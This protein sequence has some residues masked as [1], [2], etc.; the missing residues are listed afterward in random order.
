VLIRAVAALRLSGL[1]LA[2][3]ALS[4]SAALWASPEPES[5]LSP[6]EVSASRSREGERARDGRH[7]ELSELV[8]EGGLSVR[9]LGGMGSASVLSARGGGAHQLDLSLEG[10]PL[11][12]AQSQGFDLS[13]FPSLVFQG[14][15]LSEGVLSGGSGAQTAQ[16]NLRLPRLEQGS[17]QRA[18]LM[19]STE[20]GAELGL[21]AGQAGEG[22]A[23]GVWLAY[24]GG[25]GAFR[26]RDRY[27]LLKRR[28]GADFER[29]SVGL[30]AQ[31]RVADR[32]L[33]GFIALAGLERGEPGPEGL[34]A[35]RGLSE[36]G[37]VAASLRLAPIEQ[38]GSWAPEGQ[39]FMSARSYLYSEDQPLWQSAEALRHLMESRLGGARL[40]WG[41]RPLASAER[42][43]E[44][45][46]AGRA[47]EAGVTLDAR[48]EESLISSGEEATLRHARSRLA[49]SPR[50]ALALPSGSWQLIALSGAARLDLN[51]ERSA[52]WIPSLSLAASPSASARCEL[53]FSRAFR[54]PSFDERYLRGPG[55]IPNPSLSFEDGWWTDLGCRLKLQGR[56]SS[57]KLSALGFSQVY[58]RLI[59]YVPLDPYRIQASDD[60]GAE[61][62]GVTLRAQLKHRLSAP[63]PVLRLEGQLTGQR[64][65][66][67]S[68]P[69]TPLPLRPELYAWGRLAL[70]LRPSALWLKLSHRGAL[71]ADR[72]GLRTLA[73]ATLLDL[74]LERSWSLSPAQA[75]RLSLNVAL[76]NL[77]DASVRDATLRPLPGRSLWLNLSLELD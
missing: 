20:R 75:Q 70:S 65:A 76:R 61:V 2:L 1:S 37:S 52:L 56:R 27:G 5:S 71:Y 31:R 58:E 6:L 22:G 39:L 10:V 17:S 32:S 12:G 50:L 49:L 45:A 21:W 9:R 25:S 30:S 66:L 63:W 74:G 41:T 53:R 46:Q 64:H 59:L 19:L 34:E 73:P 60:A 62:L 33:S 35:Q 42:E 43:G 8:E 26:Y 18:E 7:R 14:L 68:P 57:A 3:Q 38:R 72:Y 47:W 29:A 69:Y 51:S 16:L 13:L 24:G 23:L 36:Q 4:G 15:E 44:R 77:L 54:D 28:E 11:Q 55:V 67:T 40:S 48:Y